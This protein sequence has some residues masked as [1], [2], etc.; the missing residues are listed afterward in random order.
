MVLA[1]K[2]GKKQS[3]VKKEAN[4]T[5]APKVPAVP[6]G[7]VQM[8]EEG[9]EEM[10]IITGVFKNEDGSL[11]GKVKDG[12]FVRMVPFKTNGGKA[13]MELLMGDSKDKLE[14]VVGLFE[15]T[16]KAGN[17][18]FSGSI[19]KDDGTYGDQFFFFYRKEK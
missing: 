3:E 7:F 13:G 9:A 12:P 15:K 17:V 14:K 2:S 8:K 19:K 6:V 1:M 18:F 4:M 10:Q 5:Q 16:S 11:S